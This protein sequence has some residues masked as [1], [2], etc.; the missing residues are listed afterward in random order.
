VGSEKTLVDS[1][2]RFDVITD[3]IVASKPE[4][5]TT[6]LSTKLIDLVQMP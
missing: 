3:S 2:V 4:M 1:A 6:L 5:R